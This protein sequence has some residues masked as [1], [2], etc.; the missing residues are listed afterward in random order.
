M[1]TA[2]T[3]TITRSDGTLVVIELCPD[4]EG[5]PASASQHFR[6]ADVRRFCSCPFDRA[7]P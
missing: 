4:C 5:R 7:H 6:R 1:V 3:E 2:T